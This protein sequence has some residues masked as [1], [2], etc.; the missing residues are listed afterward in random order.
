VWKMFGMEFVQGR[1]PSLARLRAGSGGKGHNW[2]W[3]ARQVKE[4]NGDVTP[5]D[6]GRTPRAGGRAPKSISTLDLSAKR[7][8]ISLVFARRPAMLVLSLCGPL[9]FAQDR[10]VLTALKE[11]AFAHSQGVEDVFYLADVFGPRFMDLPGYVKAGDWAV[12]RLHSYGLAKCGEGIFRYTRT[13][14]GIQRC[15]GGDDS[16]IVQPH[17]GVSACAKSRH[18]GRGVGRADSSCGHHGAGVSGVSFAFIVAS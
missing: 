3:A 17:C 16:A 13:G 12:T 7:D 18:E 15:F 4:C 14:L 9:L 10:A 5:N 8:G 6:L 11:Q 1:S 2:G